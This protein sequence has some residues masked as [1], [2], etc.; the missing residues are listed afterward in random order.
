MTQLANQSSSSH[1]QRSSTLSQNRVRVAIYTRLS[2]QSDPNLEFTSLAAQ[3]EATMKCMES[4]LGDQ[5]QIDVQYF[6]DDGFTGANTERPSFKQMFEAIDDGQFDVVAT[7]SLDRVSRDLADQLAFRRF[8]ETRRVRLISVRE[9]F[10]FDSDT[11]SLLAG[12][13][14]TFAEYERKAIARR[15]REKNHAARKRG[16][17]TGGRIVLGY[18]LVNGK[19]CPNAEEAEIVKG[20]FRLYLDLGS[21]RAVV[22]EARKRSWK[23]KHWISK[24][25]R[26]SG[27]GCIDVSWLQ[28]LLT[29]PLYIGKMKLFGEAHEGEHE[30]I[31]D[32]E[33]WQL[34]QDQL[35][36]NAH[37]RG[38]SVRNKWGALL[39]GLLRC[40]RC[41]ATMGHTGTG[42]GPK[43]YRYYVCQTAQVQGADACPDARVSAHD[44][45]SAVVQQIR[46]LGVGS[47]LARLT[48]E[49][50]QER[51]C[52]AEDEG[53]AAA[54][55]DF[56]AIWE[57]LPALQRAQVLQV[58]LREV[59]LDPDTRHIELEFR[60]SMLM[61]QPEKRDETR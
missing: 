20:L 43:R 7:P 11:G 24:A 60:E 27:G 10:D 44:V 52:P 57:A 37:S 28:R 51:G 9:P 6:E 8:L 49:A 35:S 47:E 33:T 26:S 21:L 19:L 38:R 22:V 15:T 50:L 42:K 14:G 5:S 40:G 31:V 17:F 61:E 36:H 34:V 32:E 55:R 48:L 29:N 1:A 30:A 41:G 58:L 16:L 2:V 3:A 59:R 53:A 56:D 25:G 23:K 4:R 54:L 12:I 45:E 18:D 13:L 46:G 39:K